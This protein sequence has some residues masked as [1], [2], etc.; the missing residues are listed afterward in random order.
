LFGREVA[1]RTLHRTEVRELSKESEQETLSNV[2]PLW[3][4]DPLVNVSFLYFFF[5]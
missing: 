1:G 4:I 2:M 5:S 3:I